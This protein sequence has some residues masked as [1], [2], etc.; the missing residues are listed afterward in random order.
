M[1]AR[2]EMLAAQMAWM[3]ELLDDRHYTLEREDKSSESFA[4]PF[5]GRRPRA[6]SIDDK[7][8]ESGLRID[9]VNLRK[10]STWRIIGLD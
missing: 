3:A 8:W 4:N 10:W 6:E 5:S 7:R 1:I 9:I 2:I